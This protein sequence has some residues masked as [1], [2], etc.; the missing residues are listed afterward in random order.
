MQILLDCQPIQSIVSLDASLSRQH[1]IA[2]QKQALHAYRLE[3]LSQLLNRDVQAEEILKTAYG[4]PYLTDLAFNHSHSQQHYALVMSRDVQDIGVDVEDLGRQVRFEALAQHAFTAN[5]L[6]RWYDSGQDQAFWFQ[7]WTTKE[8]I[9]KAAGLGIRL[10]LNTLDTYTT[11]GQMQGQ[12]V[13]PQLGSFNYQNMCLHQAMLTI[14]WRTT[15]AMP[16]IQV[17]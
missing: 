13:H 11:F 3:K 10:S 16:S 5:E 14:A 12:M 15:A 1:Y 6:Q 4:K 17:L 2:Q 8:A 7:I 9:V